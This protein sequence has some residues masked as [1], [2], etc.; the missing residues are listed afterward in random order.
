MRMDT[1]AQ[2]TDSRERERESEGKKDIERNR[3]KK[4]RG[5]ERED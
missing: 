4:R 2:G 1:E 5:K 3:L